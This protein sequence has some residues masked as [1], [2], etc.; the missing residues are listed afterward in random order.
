MH[1]KSDSKPL[2]RA[3]VACARCR[4]RKVRCD[5]AING[6]WCTN[7]RLDGVACVVVYAKKTKRFVRPEKF[8]LSFTEVD[9]DRR[10]GTV[11]TQRAASAKGSMRPERR[12]FADHTGPVTDCEV[13]VN[14]TGGTQAS[15]R[16]IDGTE[17]SI[18][19][20]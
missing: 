17:E 10:K 15:S 4:G 19:M 7:C 1:P 9:G 11:A 18:G 2:K 5:V 12:A 3:S 6:R 13:T 8:V 14:P 20:L 16:R